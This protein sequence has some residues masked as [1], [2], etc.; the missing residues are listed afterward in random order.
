MSTSGHYTIWN[1]FKILEVYNLQLTKSTIFMLHQQ[2]ILQETIIRVSLV[3]GV[4]D[5]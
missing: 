3:E 4:Q 1:V 5:S 2:L